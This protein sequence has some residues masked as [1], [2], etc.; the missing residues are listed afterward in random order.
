MYSH[1]LIDLI[2]VA[3]VQKQLSQQLDYLLAFRFFLPLAQ[4]GCC[5]VITPESTVPRSW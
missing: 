3:N 2:I 1:F 5:P 4:A